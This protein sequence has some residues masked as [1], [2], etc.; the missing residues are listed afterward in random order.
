[1][2]TKENKSTIQLR[3]TNEL[4]RAIFQGIFT[5]GERLIQEE[6][7]ERL[8]VSRMP[9]R[10][11]LKQLELEGL[12]KVEPRKGAIVTPITSHDI[13]EIYTV[14]SFLEVLAVEKALPY[15]TKQDEQKLEQLLLK[16]EGLTI[17]NENVKDYIQLNNDFHKLLRERCPWV[18]VKQQIDMLW[19]GFL[20]FSSPNILSHCY[21]Q[22]K[23]EHR[24]IFEAVKKREPE[25]V[26][27][28]LRY[29]IQRNKS[30]LLSV[31]DKSKNGKEG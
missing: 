18:R 4:R 20:P 30:S 11:A 8:G 22:A 28:T 14:R 3:V 26:K 31:M 2:T 6:W 15:I 27:L 29:H 7:A 1:M 17:T 23:D 24:M 25:M 21:D 12:V 19:L 10:E 13:Q 9:I 16:M 5:E